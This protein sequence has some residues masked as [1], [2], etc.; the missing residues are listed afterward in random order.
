MRTYPYPKAALKNTM[1]VDPGHYLASSN[2][3]K[4][5]LLK[6]KGIESKPE[7]NG[8]FGQAVSFAGG[9]YVVAVIDSSHSQQDQPQFLKLKPDNLE[10]ATQFDQLKFGARMMAESAKEFA[11]GPK[12]D[13][14][15]NRVISALPL[16]LGSKLTPKTALFACAAISQLVLLMV[17]KLVG[18]VVGVWKVF[19]FVSM[20]AFVLS[21]ASPDIVDGMRANKPY[22]LIAK[23]AAR[24]LGMRW[25]EQ[26]AQMTGFRIS[27]RMALGLLVALLLF[28]GKVLLT[29]TRS[30]PPRPPRPSTPPIPQYDLEYIYKL[31]FEDATA[32]RE[33][34]ASLPDNV[35]V[36]ADL[37]QPIDQYE[38]EKPNYEMPYDPQPKARGSSFGVGSMLSMFTIYRF[39]KDLITSPDG[40]IVTDPAYI[41]ARLRQ[42]ESWRLGLLAMSAYRVVKSLGII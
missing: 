37:T 28:C 26:V 30:T 13:E 10:E 8:R 24:N 3:G 19:V 21:I 16:S 35:A 36:E 6:L 14:Y 40:Q 38:Y 23:S 27:D 9:R 7:L 1:S 15:G 42:M 5:Q 33:F 17:L 41:M 22:S 39:G 31:G 4:P 18:R 29:T 20:V 34:G 11:R 25:K 2:D 12:I 32:S